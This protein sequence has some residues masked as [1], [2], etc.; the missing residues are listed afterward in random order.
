LIS[1]RAGASVARSVQAA[2]LEATQQRR[3]RQSA[4]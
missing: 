1:E 3:V 4:A 2:E